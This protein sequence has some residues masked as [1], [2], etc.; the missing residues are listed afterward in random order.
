MGRPP[1]FKNEKAL[2]AAVEEYFAELPEKT[3]PT[4]AGLRLHLG[5]TRETYSSWKADAHLFADTIK[6]ADTIIE[7][8]WLQC[9][10]RPQPTGAIFYLKN[11]F[12]ED[13]KDRLE[14]TGEDGGAII[15]NIEVSFK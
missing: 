15:H 14:H 12:K 7:I 3:M 13:Y 5:I 11:A 1:K 2:K 8:A 10:T 9:L 4:K 6:E